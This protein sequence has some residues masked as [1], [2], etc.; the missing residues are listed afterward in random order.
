[1]VPN[2]SETPES[3]LARREAVLARRVNGNGMGTPLSMA[4]KLWPTPRAEDAETAHEHPNRSNPDSLNGML[5]SARWA[6]P[7]GRDWRDGRAGPETLTR[8]LRRPLNEQ[9]VTLWATPAAADGER[10]SDEMMR[11]NPTLQGQ[12]RLWPTPTSQDARSSGTAAYPETSTHK[13]GTTL[14]DAARE[15]RWSTPR[16]RADRS[17]RK[18]LT[19]RHWSQ[20]SLEQMAELAAG[21]IPRELASPDEL[22]PRARRIYEAGGTTPGTASRESGTTTP[23]PS[24]PP[25]PPTAPAGPPCRRV[26]N[27]RF[28]EMLMGWVPGW[29]DFAPLETASYRSWQ[30][31]R[32]SALRAAWASTR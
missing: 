2:D 24:G 13:P 1:M 23:S 9:A 32:S 14:T 8:H 26:L 31:R 15:D 25:D 6:T 12:A 16:A 30:A 19:Q 18:A 10:G 7:A 21:E 29:T 5:R 11:G 27:P 20:P 4:A 28:V 17:S 3:W 22:T